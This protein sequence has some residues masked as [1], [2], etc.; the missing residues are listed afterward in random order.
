MAKNDPRM[1][2]AEVQYQATPKAGLHCADCGN[3]RPEDGCTLVKGI[4][5]PQ[6][7]CRLYD[8]PQEAAEKPK[9]GRRTKKLTLGRQ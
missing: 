6:G 2:K 3:F 1:T 5:G 9:R 8:G 4:I 7:W